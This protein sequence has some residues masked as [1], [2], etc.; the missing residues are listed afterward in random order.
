MRQ[1]IVAGNWKMH[2]DVDAAGQ[3][4]REIR[5]GLHVS[6]GS[7]FGAV[8]CPPFP[9]L[10][11][12]HAALD[13]SAVGLGAQNMHFEASG[14]FTG[15]VAPGM[16]TSVGCTHVI[17]GHSER[18]QYFGEEDVLINRKAKAALLHALTPI[19]C[20]GETL[21]ERENGSTAAVVTRQIQ[22]VL[23]G[24][25]QEQLHRI[26]LAYEPV[27]AIGTGRTATPEQAQDV[28]AIIRQVIAAMH[29]AGPASGI[30]ILYGGSVKA[31]NAAD[32]FS[33][34]DVDGGLIGGA[35]LKAGD[36]LA[37]C[38]AGLAVS[39]ARASL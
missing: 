33:Q 4:A 27:W 24:M 2:L 17:L 8:L 26:V 25:H 7:A 30:P 21:Q 28:H 5:R 34:E 15:E 19:L 16:L 9:F 36:F 14:A 23:D 29:G 6:S 1:V 12:V 38:E 31:D 10:P 32:L 3:L 37:I 18:R 39:A 22:G 20:V 11:I 35:S 13:G